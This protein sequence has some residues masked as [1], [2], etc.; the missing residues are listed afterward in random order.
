MTGRTP[1]LGAEPRGKP[2]SLEDLLGLANAI[3]HEAVD[4]YTQLA[5]LMEVRGERDTA[6]T[7]REMC[8]I[9]QR[10]VDMVARR[11][12]SLGERLPPASDFTWR[13]PPEIGASWNDVE[14]SLLLTPYRALAIAVTNEERAFALYSYV[15]AAADDPAVA[16]Q[17]ES[18]AREE[19][20]HAAELRVR[21]RR[22]YHRAAPGAAPPVGTDIESLSDLRALEVRISRN[23]DATLG[24]IAVALD[25]AGDPESA[26]LVASLAHTAAEPGKAAPAPATAASGQQT[27]QGL[28]R[29]ALRTLETASEAYEEVV[30]RTERDDLLQAAQT[31][32]QGVVEGISALA[33]RLSEIDARHD[34]AAI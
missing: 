18:L 32:L 14:H 28:L 9:E 30:T 11:A 1:L 20:A 8:E 33:F 17:A 25:A 5:E 12:E 23:I 6:D 10:H 22:A 31:S 13:L 27:P 16:R 15:A 3:D 24:D 34:N 26:G 4:R 29:Q 19:L 21:R 2:A 7:F